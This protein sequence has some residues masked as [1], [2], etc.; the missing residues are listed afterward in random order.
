MIQPNTRF[1]N[2]VTPHLE[3]NRKRSVKVPIGLIGEEERE[4]EKERESGGFPISDL[5][6]EIFKF[7]QEFILLETPEIIRLFGVNTDYR[8]RNVDSTS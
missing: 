4:K 1:H 3:K 7:F 5:M 8:E 6:W 2:F